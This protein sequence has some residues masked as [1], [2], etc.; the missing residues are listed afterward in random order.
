MKM[1]AGVQFLAWVRMNL[2]VIRYRMVP[3]PK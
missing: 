3:M 1:T 2:F